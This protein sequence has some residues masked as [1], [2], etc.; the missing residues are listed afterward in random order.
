M[1]DAVV[2][3]EYKNF[4]W[5]IFSLTQWPLIIINLLLSF[6]N[7][8]FEDISNYYYFL[9][10]PIFIISLLFF[11]KNNSF[12]KISKGFKITNDKI[13][14]DRFK[15]FEEIVI[16]EIVQLDETLDKFEVKDK[17]DKTINLPVEKLS[18]KKMIE[19]MHLVKSILPKN[20][21]I[22]P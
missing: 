22:I 17:N 14:I 5:N 20:T 7:L 4:D 8:F 19:C 1:S 16:K 10:I 11:D 2:V 18:K 6:S 21:A 12:K 15:F 9:L 3:K 13:I